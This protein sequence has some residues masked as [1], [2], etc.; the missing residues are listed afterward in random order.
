M[1]IVGY[2]PIKT[3]YSPAYS[4]FYFHNEN[5]YKDTCKIDHVKTGLNY[6]VNVM[7][8]YLWVNRR[9]LTALSLARALLFPGLNSGESATDFA[10][11]S[12]LGGQD[13]LLL[14]AK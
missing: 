9:P 7:F 6:P 10:L 3:L 12:A 13:R 2:Q 4:T 8:I 14:L 11:V 1:N 5:F